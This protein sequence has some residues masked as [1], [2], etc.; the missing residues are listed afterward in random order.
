MFI[1]WKGKYAYLEQRYLDNGKVKCRSKYLGQNPFDA[2]A[3]MFSAGE[4]DQR[5]YESIVKWKP[6]G[7]LQPTEDGGLNINGG[8]FGFWKGAKIGLY[9]GHH[10]LY[11]RVEKDE[12]GWHLADDNGNILGLKPGVKARL[13]I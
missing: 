12:H 5:A 6:E 7:I 3:K 9:F 10:W 11:G 8:T 13:W 2:L 4:I 1:R